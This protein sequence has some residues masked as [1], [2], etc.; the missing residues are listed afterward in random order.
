MV[1]LE[2]V[3]GP[4][5]RWLMGR[6]PFVQHGPSVTAVQ[7]S[8]SRRLVTVDVGVDVPLPKSRMDGAIVRLRPSGL[9]TADD[10]VFAEDAVRSLGAAAV[11]RLPLSRADVP[12]VEGT[13]V[14]EGAID[15]DSIAEAL[16]TVVRR[17][18]ASSDPE[19]V[20][21]VVGLADKLL[22]EVG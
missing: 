1:V 4:E 21:V 9:C 8:G 2:G 10:M 15:G 16:R 22:G 18:M 13:A 20:E 14:G 19:E 3:H 5:A 7:V 12:E 11:V 6:Q 17:M